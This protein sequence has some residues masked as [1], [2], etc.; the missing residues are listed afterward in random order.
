MLRGYPSRAVTG[1][2]HGRFVVRRVGLEPTRPCG[3][4]DLNPARLP[5]PPPALVVAIVSVASSHACGAMQHNRYLLNTTA[6]GVSR[7]PGQP[8]A[9]VP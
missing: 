5:I 3:H 2:D 4:R 7:A 8:L 6:M 1:D 9:I